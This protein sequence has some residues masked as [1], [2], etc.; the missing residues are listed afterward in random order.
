MLLTSAFTL[1]LLPSYVPHSEVADP[2]LRAL[3]DRKEGWSLGDGFQLSGLGAIA[4][5]VQQVFN[6][7][8]LCARRSAPRLL[9]IATTGRRR[10]PSLLCRHSAAT[11]CQS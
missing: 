8:L 4:Y 5:S 7:H 9:S 3:V 2:A 6:E 1:S 10:G 11:A